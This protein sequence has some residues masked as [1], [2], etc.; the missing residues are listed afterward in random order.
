MAWLP[1]SADA[2][3]WKHPSH[4]QAQWTH[5]T[6]IWNIGYLSGGYACHFLQ[7]LKKRGVHVKDLWQTEQMDGLTSFHILGQSYTNQSYLKTA[8][9]SKIPNERHGHNLMSSLCQATLCTALFAATTIFVL[10]NLCILLHNDPSCTDIKII[11]HD[12]C[13][14]SKHIHKKSFQI[15]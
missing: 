6:H 1:H 9:T 11:A 13:Y 2:Q 3:L 15:Y 7:L 8:V 10:Y 14:L 12:H 5:E 4:P